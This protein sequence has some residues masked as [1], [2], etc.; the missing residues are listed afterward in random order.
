MIIIYFTLIKEIFAVRVYGKDVGFQKVRSLNVSGTYYPIEKLKLSMDGILKEFPNLREKFDKIE[1]PKKAES[2]VK[3]IAIQRFKEH[4]K[5]MEDEIQISRY[6]VEELEKSNYK[7]KAY[8]KKGF[9]LIKTQN[10]ADIR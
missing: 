9:R 5:S 3:T 1:D 7:L 10:G 6:V 2:E 4:I 8:Q